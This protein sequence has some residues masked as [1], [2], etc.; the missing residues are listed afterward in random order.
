[1]IIPELLR[2]KETLERHI[3][4]LEEW[5]NRAP[6][7]RLCVSS[8]KKGDFI[9]YRYF[10]PGEK[11]LFPKKDLPLIKALVARKYYQK[12][13]SLMKKA[14]LLV[15]SLIETE[16]QIAASYENLHVARKT[17]ISPVEKSVRKEIESFLSEEFPPSEYAIKN[18]NETLKGDIV[19]SWPE[20]L[21]ADALFRARIPY[22]YEKP[23]VLYNGHTI[24]PDF[25]I[26]HPV[27]GEVFIWEHFGRTDKPSYMGDSV[28]KIKDY[29]K[30]GAIIGKGLIATFDNDEFK[31]TNEEIRQIIKEYFL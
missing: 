13:L 2:R 15:T 11:E 8:R 28:K 18:P 27:T 24:R 5:L 1:M 12:V 7:E 29:A 6:K 4:S 9:V 23:F 3:V 16:R 21:I 10:I 22:R 26:M 14:L 25:T 30:S 17:L 20:L 31:L 19:R